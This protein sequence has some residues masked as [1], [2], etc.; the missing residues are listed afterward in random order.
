LQFGKIRVGRTIKKTVI[1]RNDG[2]MPATAKFELD[3]HD[4]F[5]FVDQAI[6]TLSPGQ[7]RAFNVEFTPQKCEKFSWDISVTTLLNDYEKQVIQVQGEGYFDA[8][9][10]EQL[11]KGKEDELIFEDCVINKRR[12]IKFNIRNT[13]QDVI[14]YHWDNSEAQDFEIRPNVGHMAP[15]GIKELRGYFKSDKLA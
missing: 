8:I 1:L 12:R 7:M 2:S 13:S 9:V 5:K 14:R 4:A 10:F 15:G 6:F 11:P 3:H